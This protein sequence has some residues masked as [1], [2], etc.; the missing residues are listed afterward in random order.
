FWRWCRRNPLPAGLLAGIV[1]VF[2]AGFAGVAWQ[3]RV[4]ETARQ[5]EKSQRKDAETA[6]DEAKQAR[7][8]AARQ[9]ARLLLDPGIDDAR[10]GEPAR[11]L[12]LFVRALGALPADDPEAAPLERAIRANLS[13]WAETVPALEHI[14]PGGFHSTK[15]AYSLDSERLAM[16]VGKDE[17]RC[18]RPDTGQPVGPPVKILPSPH[19]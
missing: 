16:A 13:A 8:D 10:G 17:I 9:A 1:L 4:A 6:R 3:W 12:H 15:V 19:A 11:A 5:D 14:W 7:N 18:F 2:L